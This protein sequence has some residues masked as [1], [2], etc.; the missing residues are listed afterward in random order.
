MTYLNVSVLG[1]RG[2]LHPAVSNLTNT[3]A[4]RKMRPH[5]K[6]LAGNYLTLEEKSN[7]S[8][9]SPFCCLCDNVI[10]PE[11]LEHL[12]SRCQKMSETRSNIT[13]LMTKLCNEAGLNIDIKSLSD[14]QLCQFILDPSSLS[15]K[16]RVDIS[17]PVLPSLFQLSRDFCYSID[18]TRMIVLF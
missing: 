15:L 13:T 11:S 9:G 2:R 4:V 3:H 1:L 5:I 8:G 16:T 7:Q 6:M 14:Q 18:K 10:E 17:H 12:I